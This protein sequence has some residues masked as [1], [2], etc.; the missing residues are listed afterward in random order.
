LPITFI[1]NKAGTFVQATTDTVSNAAAGVTI[2]ED[3]RVKLVNGEGDDTYPISGFTW[4]L[5]CPNQTDAAKATA[6]TRMLWWATHDGQSYEA[7]LGYA[8]LPEVAVQADEAQILKIM[9]DGK[10]ALPTDIATPAA[11]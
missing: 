10:Q 11:S 6:L 3:E 2:P 8:P 4:L 5:V 7:A 9:V 1:Q